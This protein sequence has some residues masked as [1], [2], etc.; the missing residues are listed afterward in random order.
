MAGG[1]NLLKNA[2]GI[3]HISA[4]A[5]KKTNIVQLSPISGFLKSVCLDIKV[6]TTSPTSTSVHIIHEA[7]FYY[8][9][10]DPLIKSL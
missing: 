9:Y 10:A 2:G 5:A 8:N 1:G 7:I 3:L 4:S 6:H